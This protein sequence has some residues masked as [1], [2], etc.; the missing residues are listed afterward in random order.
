MHLLVE[1][2]QAGMLCC[3]GWISNWG[4]SIIIF[5]TLLKLVLFP[6]QIFSSRQQFKLQRL[7]PEILDLK[8]KFKND[9]MRFSAEHRRLLKQANVRPIWMIVTMVMPLPIFMGMFSAIRMNENIHLAHFAWIANL[10]APDHLLILPLLVALAMWLQTKNAP[11]APV[12]MPRYL[13]P[14]ISFVFMISLPS[15]L[16]LYSLTGSVFQLLGQKVIEAYC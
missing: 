6:L 12:K 16:V 4:L 5:T 10:A 1:F 9:T 13:M 8:E 7:N 2:L 11:L 15:A 3:Q 14:A